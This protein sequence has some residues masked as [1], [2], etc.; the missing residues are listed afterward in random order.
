MKFRF[1][2]V[3]RL[4]ESTIKTKHF[5][6]SSLQNLAT[7]NGVEGPVGY[8]QWVEPTLGCPC[9]YAGLASQSKHPGKARVRQPT[10]GKER[11]GRAYALLLQERK[12]STGSFSMGWCV[13]FTNILMEGPN[14][15][16]GSFRL[17]PNDIMYLENLA[18]LKMDYQYCSN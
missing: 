8:Y 10:D 13:L 3:T 1:Q 2:E 14:H 15:F 6:Y 5:M 7:N 4:F 12:K 17:K 11:H 18:S 16:T 9:I